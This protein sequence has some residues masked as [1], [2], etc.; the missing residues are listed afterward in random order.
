VEQ[1]R[2]QLHCAEDVKAIQTANN[3]EIRSRLLKFGNLLALQVSGKQPA[4]VK[5][6][7]DT[8]VRKVL[9]ELREFDRGVFIGGAKSP[10]SLTQAA[11]SI[12]EQQPNLKLHVTSCAG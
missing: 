12:P 4:E 11:R 7:I 2:G 1:T 9:L 10:Q 3:S 8:E 5:T 6:I